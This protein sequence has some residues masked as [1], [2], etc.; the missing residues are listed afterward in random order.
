MTALREALGRRLKLNVSTGG[1][2]TP[3]KA[4]RKK[5]H[6]GKIDTDHDSRL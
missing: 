3:E 4:L 6:K 2:N 1:D 5:T